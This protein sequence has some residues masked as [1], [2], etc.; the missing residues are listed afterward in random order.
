MFGQRIS[1]HDTHIPVIFRRSIVSSSAYTPD[2]A[3]PSRHRLCT[4]L[5][6]VSDMGPSRRSAAVRMSIM[7]AYDY[8]AEFWICWILFSCNFDNRFTVSM[9]FKRSVFMFT[10]LVCH[11]AK[12]KFATRV[13]FVG[14]SSASYFYHATHWEIA[15]TVPS[16]CLSVAV[17]YC[18]KTARHIV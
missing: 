11:S 1:V 5:C 6:C 13:V 17:R 4:Q 10:F 9:W 3:M 12:H 8:V 16:A 15:I 18:V 2:A 14:F 7:L